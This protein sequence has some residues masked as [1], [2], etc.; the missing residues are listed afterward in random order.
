MNNYFE[1]IYEYNNILLGKDSQFKSSFK[2]A[3]LKDRCAEAG[4]IWRYAIEYLL[5]WTAA[6]AA[7]YLNEEIVQSLKLDKTYKFMDI[8]PKNSYLGD[9]RSILQYAFPECVH[10]SFTEQTLKEYRRAAHIGEYINEPEDNN[11]RIPKKFFSDE[12]GIDR[13]AILMNYVIDQYLSDMS[14]EE[15]YDFFADEKQASKWLKKKKLDLPLK[16]MYDSA[17]EYFF[18]SLKAN[19]QDYFLYFVYTLNK[20]CANTMAYDN[21]LQD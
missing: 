3:N 5:G 10:Y 11:Y 13:A 6:D 12:S 14:L 9:Y 17:F 16:I 21:M 15:L 8:H 4:N 1:N 2:S 7:K 20:K 19:K 18:N